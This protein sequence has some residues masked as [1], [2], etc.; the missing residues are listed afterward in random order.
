MNVTARRALVVLCAS[1]DITADA[2]AVTGSSCAQTEAHTADKSHEELKTS[3]HESSMCHLMA[4]LNM[5]ASGGT[6]VFNVSQ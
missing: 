6:L 4:L 5:T 2:G 3:G 1:V